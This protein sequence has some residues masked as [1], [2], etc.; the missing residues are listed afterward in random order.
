MALEKHYAGACVT[1]EPR[2]IIKDNRYAEE[3]GDSIKSMLN[4]RSDGKQ[5]FLVVKE[6][7]IQ[8]CKS[9]GFSIK[10]GLS[11]CDTNPDLLEKQRILIFDPGNKQERFLVQEW[12]L[13]ADTLM[14]IKYL[15]PNPK[16]RG[17]VV[18]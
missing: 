12:D 16:V 3:L 2:Q 1:S 5:S 14:P 15:A 6:D 18:T 11:T 4:D 8:A 7:I 17:K 10:F 9:F 13:V